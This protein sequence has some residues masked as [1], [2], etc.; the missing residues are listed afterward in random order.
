MN[1]ENKT[2]I[3]ISGYIDFNINLKGTF[4]GEELQDIEFEFNPY[5]KVLESLEWRL[6]YVDSLNIEDFVQYDA[7]FYEWVRNYFYVQMQE[8]AILK[9]IEFDPCYDGDGELLGYDYVATLKLDWETLFE[10]WNL[11]KEY[12]KS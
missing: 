9:Q 6:K 10:K 7:S 5:Q 8:E 2:P 1:T 3:Q 11:E 12:E 4:S